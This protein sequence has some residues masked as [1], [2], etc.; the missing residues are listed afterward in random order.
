MTV[1]AIYGAAGKMGTRAWKALKDE[2]DLELLYIEGHEKGEGVL[3]ERGLNPSTPED[4]V[5]KADITL[6]A[7]PDKFVKD[8]SAELVPQLKS[9]SMV[10]CLDPAA[11]HAGLLPQRNDITYFITHPCHPP[12]FNDEMKMEARRDFFGSG[13]AKQ[14]IVC[15]LMQGPE[16]DYAKGEAIASKF[17]GPVLRTHRVTVEQM[18]WLEPVLSETVGATCL[19]VIRAAMDEA[20]KKGVPADAARDFIMGHINVELAILFNEVDFNFSDGALKA[21]AEA[22]KDMFQPDWKKVFSEEKLKESVLKITGQI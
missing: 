11:P 5:E 22:R 4:A 20:I 6:L 12:V 7:V 10:I 2:T 14:S 1:V 17:F 15:A 21:I 3:K 18:A 16:E 9:G 8:I 19:W 13:L